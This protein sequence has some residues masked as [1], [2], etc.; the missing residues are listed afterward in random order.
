MTLE[1]LNRNT[2]IKTIIKM[3][4]LIIYKFT[5]MYKKYDFIARCNKIACMLSIVLNMSYLGIDK[6]P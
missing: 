3:H 6:E 5:G 4:E 2:Y 1:H